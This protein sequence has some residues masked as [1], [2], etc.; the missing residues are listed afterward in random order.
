MS[1]P[2]K[3]VFF[4]VGPTAAGKSEL[5]AEIATRCNAEI[6]SA[7]AFQIYRG[8][9]IL[10][11]KP[12]TATLAK[13]THRLIGSVS[14]LDEMN[15]AKFSRMAEEV[16]GE[17]H[18]RGKLALVVGGSGLYIKALTHGL[19]PAAGANRALRAELQRLSVS[20]LAAKLTEL[21]PERMRTIDRKNPR[22]LIRAIEICMEERAS[23]GPGVVAAVADRG[24]GSTTPDTGVFVF[25]ERDEL[26]ERIARH[27]EMMFEQGVVD[28][29]RR[30]GEIGPTAS[31]TLGLREIQQLIAG[32]ISMPECVAAI[33][34]ASRRYAKRQLTWFRGQTNFEPLNLS[35]IGQTEAVEWISQ[36]AQRAYAQ[37]DD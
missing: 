30:L 25:R 15:A 8:I 5:A 27:V 24:P 10:T 13:A 28:E 1:L 32:R 21:E 34:Q 4:I 6:A 31:Q 17:I 11:A 22:R 9:D 20:E 14:I 16:I 37:T 36:K 35:H 33:Q 26:Y 3:N 12:D 23:S 2:V 19:S 29:V 7:D 18:S